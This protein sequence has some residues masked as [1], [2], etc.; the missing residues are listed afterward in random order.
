MKGAKLG[1]VTAAL[2]VLASAA[3]AGQ[4]TVGSGATV[5]LGTGSLGLGCADLTVAGTLSAGT[6]GFASAR[7]VTIDPTGVVNGNSATLQLSGDWDN[8]GSFNAGTSTVQIAD[9]C[10]LLSGVVAG[11]TSFAGLSITSTSARLVSFEAG[12]TTTVTGDLTLAGESGSLL[13]IRSTLGGSPAFLNA[14]GTSTAAFVDVDD[15]DA[16][17]GNVISLGPESVTGSNTPGW[18]FAALVPVL[19]ALGLALLGLWLL[20]IGRGALAL[21]RG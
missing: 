11:N 12:S 20:W 7:D 14:L 8:A 17:G 5:D 13:Q 9:G 18:K 3:S 4:L 21:R 16:S 2:V 15:N 1:A 6:V 10:S 19:G